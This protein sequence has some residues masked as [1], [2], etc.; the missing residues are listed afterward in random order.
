MPVTTSLPYWAL[1]VTLFAGSQV[2][3]AAAAKPP[4]PPAAAPA[5]RPAANPAANAAPNPP[6]RPAPAAADAVDPE[7]ARLRARAAFVWLSGAPLSL[8]TAG[9]DDPHGKVKAVV[10]EA[11]D[12]EVSLRNQLKAGKLA[13]AEYAKSAL[14]K[15]AAAETQIQAII[16]K[17]PRLDDAY[18]APLSTLFATSRLY[19]IAIEELAADPELT[20]KVSTKLAG[21]IAGLPNGNPDANKRENTVTEQ[22]LM[23]A[24]MIDM[25]PAD[26]QA[27]FWRLAHSAFSYRTCGRPAEH[28]PVTVKLGAESLEGV[29]KVK[30]QK[31]V[32]MPGN[33]G[34]EISD[35]ITI[36]N[37]KFSSETFASQGVKDL[38]LTVLNNN[39]FGVQY[40]SQ[41]I[42]PNGRLLYCRGVCWPDGVIRGGTIIVTPKPG[43]TETYTFVEVMPQ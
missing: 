7:V 25:V 17:R 19:T 31:N 36:R 33:A 21:Y 22:Q 20:G 16:G 6:A 38:D 23:Q 27:R 28:V 39:K 1:A 42:L 15:A 13:P 18:D 43:E 10:K 5:T 30:M 40:Q 8:E 9:F 32:G 35:V 34:R 14:Q 12:F 11:C 2:L 3:A 37:G 24:D 29:W 4:A 26:R 41:K